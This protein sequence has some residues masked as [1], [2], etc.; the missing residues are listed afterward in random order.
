V[1][2]LAQKIKQCEGLIGTSDLSAWEAEFM[3]SVVDRSSGGADTTRLSAKQ[4]E[5]VERIFGKH[6]A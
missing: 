1:K 2:S 5:V 3:Q 4:V 6:F